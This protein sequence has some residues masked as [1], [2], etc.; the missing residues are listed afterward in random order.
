MAEIRGPIS[1]DIFNMTDVQMG[2]YKSILRL[3]MRIPPS[4]QFGRWDARSPG[5]SRL[6]GGIAD[7]AGL[8]SSMAYLVYRGFKTRRE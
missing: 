5:M 1:V 7:N 6:I 2:A 8:S 4:H 3:G